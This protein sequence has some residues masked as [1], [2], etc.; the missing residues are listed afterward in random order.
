MFQTRPKD[1][2]ALKDYNL[3]PC[4]VLANN[5]WPGDTK[6]FISLIPQKFIKEV[7]F[8]IMTD[9]LYKLLLNILKKFSSYLN[10]VTLRFL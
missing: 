10:K 1:R 4:S 7:L 2:K 5:Q 6:C 9:L 3:M 8:F